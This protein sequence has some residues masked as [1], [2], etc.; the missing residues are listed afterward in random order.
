MKNY[1]IKR[2]TKLNRINNFFLIPPH[3][4]GVINGHSTSIRA[5]TIEVL[6]A[7]LI[8]QIPKNA[9]YKWCQTQKLLA[10]CNN[11]LLIVP[12]HCS[13]LLLFFFFN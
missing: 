8:P 4:F 5:F 3:I 11:N 1:G 9:L 12:S 7:I 13:K 2:N 6:K 10:I